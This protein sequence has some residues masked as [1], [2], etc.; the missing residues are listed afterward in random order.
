M[1]RFSLLILLSIESS[2]EKSSTSLTS[3]ANLLPSTPYFTVF[4]KLAAQGATLVN[5]KNE[6]IH[7]LLL[8]LLGY[9]ML[10]LRFQFIHKKR[11][12]AAEVSKIVSSN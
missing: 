7:L 8:L 10:Y 5:I 6:V 2:F 11:S 4:N 9:L 12:A 3:F 1:L